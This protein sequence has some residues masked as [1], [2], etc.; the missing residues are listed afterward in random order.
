MQSRPTSGSP[1]SRDQTGGTGHTPAPRGVGCVQKVGCVRY[2]PWQG[3]W[4]NCPAP[5]PCPSAPSAIDI[6]WH[7]PLMEKRA[8]PPRRVSQKDMQAG[9]DLTHRWTRRMERKATSTG[10]HAGWE[11]ATTNTGGHAGWKG[12]T[13]NTGGHAEWKGATTNTHPEAHIDRGHTAWKGERPWP[14]LSQPHA[15]RPAC[16]GPCARCSVSRAHA[17]P[18]LR[19]HPHRPH[20][21][22]RRRLLQ[23]R[24]E[25][26]SGRQVL[27]P[28]G[29]RRHLFVRMHQ[30]GQVVVWRGHAAQH[31][32][33]G[34]GGM[35]RST[36]ARLTRACGGA[37]SQD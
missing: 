13:T 19:L 35:R 28:I 4:G 32:R 2:G 16:H 8:L 31:H 1:V 24:P 26:A 14:L 37:P 20:L 17:T 22:R 11:G 5:S 15:R 30:T 29:H 18:P 7:V 6:T 3:L 12:A 23:L 33:K 36:I 34:D 25:C 9:G 21:A 27:D 10:G